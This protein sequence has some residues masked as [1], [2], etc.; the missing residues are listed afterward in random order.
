[1]RS[2]AARSRARI[3]QAARGQP[4]HSIRLNDIARETGLGVGTVYRH[5]ATVTALIEAL[6]IDALQ[7]LAGTARRAA[8]SSTPGAEFIDLVKR[9]AELQLARAGLKEL[10][11]AEDVSP[12]A[13]SLRAEF[14]HYASVALDAA[15]RERRVRPEISIEHIQ[16]LACAVEYAARLGEEADHPL[17][18]DV[19]VN[20]LRLHEEIAP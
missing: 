7:E 20:G 2:D 19:L 6:N 4:P 3:L 9:G 8:Q 18:L 10:L 11:I 15:I 1:M 16:Q 13:R 5:F 17:L 12:D 14:R